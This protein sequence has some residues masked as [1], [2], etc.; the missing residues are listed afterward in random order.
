[1]YYEVT[2]YKDNVLSIVPFTAEQT[3]VTS[4][5]W[6]A[7]EIRPHVQKII[8]MAIIIFNISTVITGPKETC[9]L[10]TSIET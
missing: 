5:N 3:C 7:N 4:Q 9:R 1:M 6:V 10:K 2:I 8:F